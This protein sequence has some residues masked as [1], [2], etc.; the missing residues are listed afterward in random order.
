MTIYEI[1]QHCKESSA[2][3]NSIKITQHALLSEYFW[4]YHHFSYTQ[5]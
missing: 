2:E 3:W 5:Q 1:L 4:Q